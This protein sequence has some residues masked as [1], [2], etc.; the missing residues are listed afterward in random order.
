MAHTSHTT[1][2]TPQTR[3]KARRLLELRE[4]G[5]TWDEASK[6]V[7]ILKEDGSPDP[8]LAYKIAMEG[9]EPVKQET[10]DRLGLKKICLS[11]GRAI[12]HIR[13]TVS[14]LPPWREWWIHLSRE[15]RE[16]WIEKNYREGKR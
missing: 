14:E 8:G 1:E 11:C 9:Y 6:K 12:R 10:R 15:D 13:K 4:H 7:G 16:R 2:Q 5:K 3:R